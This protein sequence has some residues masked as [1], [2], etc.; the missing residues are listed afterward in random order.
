MSFNK[1][2]DQLRIDLPVAFKTVPLSNSGSIVSSPGT[3]NGGKPSDLKINIRESLD[4][5]DSL[6]ADY[7]ALKADDTE[8]YDDLELE[9][10]WNNVDP[11]E[12]EISEELNHPDIV[13]YQ[14]PQDHHAIAWY[15]SFH[16]A[17]KFGRWGIT[18][19]ADRFL[20][21]VRFAMESNL[22]NLSWGEVF[23]ACYKET[24]Y[25]ELFHFI[26]DIYAFRIEQNIARSTPGALNSSEH[27]IYRRYTSK[28]K[29]KLKGSDNDVEEALATAY[30]RRRLAKEKLPFDSETCLPKPLAY[31][32]RR[33]EEFMENTGFSRGIDEL[34][35]MISTASL[36][37]LIV[38]TKF[39]T[40]PNKSQIKSLG[41]IRCVG[42]PL[43]KSIFAGLFG[44]AFVDRR[45]FERCL[46]KLN[47][48]IDQ[49]RR[50]S[51]PH[52]KRV[53]YSGP[54]SS[55]SAH[56]TRPVTVKE[57]GDRVNM[58]LARQIQ[59]SFGHLDPGITAANIKSC[60]RA[61]AK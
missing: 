55:A 25:H 11:W 34:G 3:R 17:D 27:G 43:A 58:G 16:Y 39:E 45:K 1:E 6:L 8:K 52:P 54:T 5:I 30:S 19:H 47:L 10:I 50:G 53:L 18:F 12:R 20:S 2:I 38:P 28:V 13:L 44:Q 49:P 21:E 51:S 56:P 4:E 60:L 41:E 59:E 22:H 40:N 14:K 35:S 61:G 33:Y 42:S 37:G 29:S 32:Y 9:R 36:Q 31:G 48:V 15:Q 46:K 57:F 24:Y 23:S 26:S 7:R